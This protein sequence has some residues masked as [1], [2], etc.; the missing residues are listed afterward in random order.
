M[1]LSQGLVLG[2][3]RG[4]AIRVHW[5]WLF[6]VA[7]LSWSLANGYFSEEF[8]W[9]A[10]KRWGWAIGCALF[11]FT[12][13]LLHELSHA[14]VALHYRM[15][16][17]SITLFI[18]GGVSSIEGE[19]QSPGQEFRVA[20]AGPLLSLVLGMTLATAGI[21]TGGDTGSVI[22]YLG[23]ANVTLG[24][25]NL[26][27]GF[28]LDGGRVFRSAA[29]AKTGDLTKATRIAAA[30]GTG[31]AWLLIAVGVLWVLFISLAGAWY[32]LIGYFLKTASESA[33][34]QVLVDKMLAPLSVRDVMRDPP[35]PVD[36]GTLLST[37]IDTRVVSRGERCVLLSH[38]GSVSGIITVTD[39]A[40]VPRERLEATRASEV[41]VA[42]ADVVT[43]TPS[44]SVSEAMRL[45]VERDL[46]QLP[47]I[48]DG[49]LLGIVGRGDVLQQV[50]ARLRFGR[51]PR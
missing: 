16:V 49:R 47:V 48:E 44:T 18:F 21:L 38:G 1:D 19:M 14:F 28:P 17:P 7:L 33:L 8:A 3:I 40:R 42:A 51:V 11:F 41:M 35:E 45:M 29:W 20:I 24:I 15:R 27:P 4:I 13:V 9:S 26:L 36:E 32:I 23:F 25:F 34:G 2:R 10:P 30:L 46:H 31:I 12:S 50:E 37:I 6:V 5:S 22:V 43:V 39:L